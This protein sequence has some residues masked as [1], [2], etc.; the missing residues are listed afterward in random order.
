MQGTV[1]MRAEDIRRSWF[2]VD[3]SGK[4]LGRLASEIARVLRGKHRPTFTTHVDT[5]DFVV[6]INAD[7]VALTGN[8]MRDKEYYAFSGYP[9]GLR[10]TKAEDMLKR[11]PTHL[12]EH[13]VRGMLP[14]NPL[15]RKMATKL[16][17]YAGAEH[18]HQ[19]QQPKP[20][21]VRL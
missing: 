3:A 15:G 14:K 16:K 21:Q 5:G 1:S 19:S 12:V 2:I 17:V 4:P 7:K 8:K 11:K 9:G 6:V 18:P 10:T 13:A 20:L